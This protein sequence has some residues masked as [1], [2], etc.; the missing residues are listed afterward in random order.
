MTNPPPPGNWGPPQPPYGQGQPPYGPGQW[1]P[2]QPGW[3]PPPTPP[4]SNVLK[5]LLIGV[6]VLL[7]IAISVGATL[8]V[9]RD[10]ENGPTHTANGTPPATGDIAS[11]NDTGPVSIIT[12]DP[13]CAPWRPISTTL[14]NQQDQGWKDRDITIPAEDWTSDQS[15]IH[16]AVAEAMSIAADQTIALAK[17]TPHRVMR[18]LYEQSI[19]YWRA[20][21]AAVPS[22]TEKD[23]EL[24]KVA[25]ATANT[26]ISIC[27]AID[28]GSAAARAPLSAPVGEPSNKSPTTDID[29]PPLF[30]ASGPND[31]CSRWADLQ[32]EFEKNA[33]PWVNLDP[34][35]PASNW[36]AEQ[37]SSM[38]RMGKLMSEYADDLESTGRVSGDQTF[39]DL[40]VLSASYWRAFV[41]A[42]PTYEPAD[43]YLSGAASSSGF[44][45]FNACAAVG[46]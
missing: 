35:I 17:M 8:L 41:N 14:S 29:N 26:L 10:G 3:G 13:T 12:E 45:P 33:T 23:N 25:N 15:A 22:Y 44:V 34:N 6:A 43:S 4:K 19:A 27:A 40:A 28:Q 1:S 5:W 32:L 20:Y 21:A 36:T 30:M 11:T 42:I 39:E 38:E 18:E 7:V 16:K 2:Q 31:E 24:A 46:S 9:T 37:R